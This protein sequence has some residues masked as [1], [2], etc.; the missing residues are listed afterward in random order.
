MTV[1]TNLIYA[2]RNAHVLNALMRT[3]GLLSETVFT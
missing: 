3:N 1:N 2:K